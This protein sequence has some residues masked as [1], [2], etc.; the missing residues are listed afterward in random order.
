MNS[1]EM[2]KRLRRM[3]LQ[4]FPELGGTHLPIKGKVTAVHGDSGSVK[5]ASGTRRYSV[6]IAP[7]HPD[8]TEDK[9]RPKFKDVPLDV[10]WSGDKRGVFGL[11]KVGAVV[12]VG[13]YG[14]SSAHPF[15]DGVMPD[16][17]SVPA[18]EQ[19]QY[20]VQL[21]DQMTLSLEAEGYL[22]T[23]KDANAKLRV[24]AAGNVEIKA[25]MN[26]EVE[27]GMDVKVQAGMNA[28][29]KAA[30]DADVK[31]GLTATVEAGV[32]ANVKA[33]MVNLG[34]IGMVPVAH[35]GSIGTSAVGPVVIT[36]GSATVKTNL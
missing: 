24:E 7:L 11:P 23:L 34:M 32:E 21:N 27:A 17:S 14:G 3:I 13:F 22:V 9:T 4:L 29:V 35:V 19:G 25:D 16:G 15:I 8:G 6:D 28:E 26:V 1:D 5:V 10:P 30:L 20:L 18:V 33:P 2:L 36:T 12:R 31:A